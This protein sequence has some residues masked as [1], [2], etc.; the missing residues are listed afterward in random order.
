V[1]TGR[2]ER[3]TGHEGGLATRIRHQ[4]DRAVNIQGAKFG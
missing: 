3:F 2:Q 1:G 4:R